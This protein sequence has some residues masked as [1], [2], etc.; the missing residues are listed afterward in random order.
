MKN[1]VKILGLVAVIVVLFSNLIENQ[2]ANVEK[3][4]AMSNSA[5]NKEV[6]K[7]KKHINPFLISKRD[8]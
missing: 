2:D 4:L 5:Q 8:L 7:N 1:S 3:T 6:T